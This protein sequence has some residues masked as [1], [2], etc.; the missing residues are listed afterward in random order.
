VMRPSKIDGRRLL[1]RRSCMDPTSFS[2][3]HRGDVVI[4]LTFFSQRQSLELPS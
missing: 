2:S 1:E 3:I 4:R